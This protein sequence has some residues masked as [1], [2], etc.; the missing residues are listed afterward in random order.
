MYAQNLGTPEKYSTIIPM[1]HLFYTNK[2]YIMYMCRYYER[3]VERERE[4]EREK[5]E[6]EKEKERERKREK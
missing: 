1:T 5:E 4:R 3:R 2:I 6:R